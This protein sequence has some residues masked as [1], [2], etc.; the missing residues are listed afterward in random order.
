M[1]TPYVRS[2]RPDIEDNIESVKLGDFCPE[3]R[4]GSLPT[5]QPFDGQVFA[6]KSQGS[7]F[8]SNS[9]ASSI[10]PIVRASGRPPANQI[11]AEIPDGPAS[12]QGHRPSYTGIHETDDVV[13]AALAGGAESVEV[14]P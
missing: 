10:R 2:K 3:F 13:D 12:R 4:P 9:M 11:G 7:R 6:A 5:E 8:E 1:V 14:G